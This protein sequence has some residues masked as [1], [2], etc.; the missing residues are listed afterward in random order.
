[1][2]EGIEVLG[3]NVRSYNALKRAGVHTVEQ[4]NDMS[5]D[6]IMKIRFIG[7]GAMMDILNALERKAYRE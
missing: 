5:V 4:L 6:D 2:T 1:M 7:T 3:L